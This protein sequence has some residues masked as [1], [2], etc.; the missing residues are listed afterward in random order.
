MVCRVFCKGM[1]RIFLPDR[2][3]EARLVHFF[4]SAGTFLRYQDLSLLSYATSTDHDIE[5]PSCFEF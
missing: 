2:S 1:A 3:D 5:N 4:R